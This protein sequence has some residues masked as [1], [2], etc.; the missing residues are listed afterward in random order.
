MS[1]PQTGQG[2]PYPPHAPMMHGEGAEAPGTP[3]GSAGEGCS[4]RAPV[5]MAPRAPHDP[6]RPM[7]GSPVSEWQTWFAWHPVATVGGLRWFCRVERRLI[8]GHSWLEHG[9][10][11]Q[12]WWQ[13]RPRGLWS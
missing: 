11:G 13:Y 9:Q 3:S 2:C 1:A 8:V 12:T 7:F 10:S 4:P 5:G 6:L